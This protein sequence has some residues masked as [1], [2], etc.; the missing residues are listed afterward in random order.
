MVLTSSIIAA[1]ILGLATATTGT[2]GAI[3]SA[4]AQ[5]EMNESS[6]PVVIERPAKL[7]KKF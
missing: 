2:V 4:N 3:S 1:I 7:P 5:K 6:T